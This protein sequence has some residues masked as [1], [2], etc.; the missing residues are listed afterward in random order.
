MA[1][2][3]ELLEKIESITGNIHHEVLRIES[4]VQVCHEAMWTIEASSKATP[5]SLGMIFE[6]LE[7]M[8]CKVANDLDGLYPEIRKAA[9]AIQ[10]ESGNGQQE[11][12]QEHNLDGLK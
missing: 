2:A 5:F 11:E 3:K 10:C 7:K 1:D 4:L 9:G 8:V 6:T 12:T